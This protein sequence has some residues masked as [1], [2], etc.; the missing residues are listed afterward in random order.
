MNKSLK[1]W[2][3]AAILAICGAI[4]F[5]ASANDDSAAVVKEADVT[6]SQSRV[7]YSAC[8]TQVSYTHCDPLPK[9]GKPELVSGTWEMNDG[10]LQHKAC[11]QAPLA[12]CN[13]VIPSDHYTIQCTARKDSG[14]DGFIIVFNYV[15]AQHYCLLNYGCERNT[16][17]AIEQIIGNK[18]KQMATRPGSVETGKWYDVKL[19]VAGDTIKAWLDSELMFDEKLNMK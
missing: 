14:P 7:G 3:F 19:T 16:K 2:M 18:R 13:Y 4:V 12:I 5:I 6:P 8:E 1:L 9:T 15:D 10:I 11:E 17:H